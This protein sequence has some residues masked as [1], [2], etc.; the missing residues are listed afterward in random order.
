MCRLWRRV[1]CG[2]AVVFKI[3]QCETLRALA[4]KKPTNKLPTKIL[5]YSE[6]DWYYSCLIKHIIKNALYINLIHNISHLKSHE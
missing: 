1:Y 4:L 6:F 3:A 5:E 2:A